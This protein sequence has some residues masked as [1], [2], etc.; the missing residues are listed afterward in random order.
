MVLLQTWMTFGLVDVMMEYSH[1][2]FHHL[3]EKTDKIG[4]VYLL[5]GDPAHHILD[6]F[7]GQLQHTALP[8]SQLQTSFNDATASV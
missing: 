4:A 7:E 5:Q 2:V 3:Q 1:K 8:L 6:Y